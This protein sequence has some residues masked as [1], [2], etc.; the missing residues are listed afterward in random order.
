MSLAI[1]LVG[2]DG[3]SI[4][5]HQ[6]TIPPYG[7]GQANDILPANVDDA[8]AVVST[9][10]AGA[11][12]FA[13][14]SVVDNSTGDPILV[15]SGAYAAELFIPATAHVLGLA[16]TDWRTNLEIANF[17]NQPVECSIDLLK[18]GFGNTSP[19]STTVTVPASSNVRVRDVLYELFN[20]DG[21]AA[22]RLSSDGPLLAATSSTFNTTDDGTYGQFIPGTTSDLAIQPNRRGLMVQLSQSDANASG[23]RTNLGLLN[24]TGIQVE[25]LI[26]LYDFDGSLLGSSS[27][28]LKPFEHRQINRVFRD[29]TTDAV[30]NGFA[31]VS[32]S[33][34][35]GAVLAYA[36]VV[37]N[38]SGDPVY[39]PAW[40]KRLGG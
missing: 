40:V 35:Q 8:M 15:L 10:T 19:E 6:A 3:V 24:I 28:V 32:T 1:D 25:V 18:T 33:T 16:G 26:E 17:K 9:S 7:H 14:G 20:H 11:T 30:S 37:D 31:W 34:P 27:T 23:F 36:S 13:Y 4:G 21:S 22:L 39:L 12:F 29:V 2:A 5:S 38:R